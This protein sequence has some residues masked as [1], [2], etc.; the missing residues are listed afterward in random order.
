[1][2]V[3]SR[4]V[5]MPASAE[6]AGRNGGR[7]P[8]LRDQPDTAAN[9]SL[10]SAVLEQDACGRSWAPMA[11]QAASAAEL[12][13][14]A[15]SS[16]TR[17]EG[18][19]RDVHRLEA[20]RHEHS[21]L[22][23]AKVRG[24][25]LRR[26]AGPGA[27]RCLS[28]ARGSASTTGS[29]RRRAARTALPTASNPCRSRCRRGGQYAETS[30]RVRL[31]N[32]CR[33]PRSGSSW[34]CRRCPAPGA[35]SIR[36]ARQCGASATMPASM[37]RSAWRS[38]TPQSDGRR[39]PVRWC[40]LHGRSCRREPWS[41]AAEPLFLG[42]PGGRPSAP[43]LRGR[44]PAGDACARSCGRRPPRPSAPRSAQEHHRWRARRAR[45]SG[46][47]LAGVAP[48]RWHSCSP[49]PGCARR[50]RRQ[51]R[52]SWR[53][54]ACSGAPERSRHAHRGCAASRQGRTRICRRC[55]AAPD[56]TWTPG[57]D[58]SPAALLCSRHLCATSRRG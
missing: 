58:H 37:G 53:C 45:T 47:H 8:R 23:R 20:T 49:T 46:M 51:K 35:A 1:M 32:G 26:R 4:C 21:P 39:A 22:W 42:R 27:P 56:L 9:R 52:L 50:S 54:R 40:P 33:P 24:E 25:S 11:S 10:P 29:R 55:L 5:R 57:L 28:G 15:A 13:R 43:R 3:G 17:L 34:G 18:D 2:E 31:P 12:L 14:N 48:G 38:P 44:A 41:G 6:A 36:P 30:C 16:R 7:T 19:Q